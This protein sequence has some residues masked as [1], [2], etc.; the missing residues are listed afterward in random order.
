MISGC[1]DQKRGESDKPKKIPNEMSPVSECP[2]DE[3]VA[4]SI[5]G[6]NLPRSFETARRSSAKITVLNFFIQIFLC[7]MV[8]IKIFIKNLGLRLFR[9]YRAIIS[10]FV[11]KPGLTGFG[12]TCPNKTT[13]MIL[14]NRQRYHSDHKQGLR[15]SKAR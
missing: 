15:A 6:D 2:E 7:W 1:K 13:F 5:Q 11:S 9:Q 10:D 8:Y 14:K 12:R 4:L 3:P